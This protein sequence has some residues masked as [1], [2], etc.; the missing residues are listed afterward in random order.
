MAAGPHP[1]RLSRLAYARRVLRDDFP[2][3]QRLRGLATPAACRGSLTLAAYF[4]TTFR[5]VNDSVGLPSRRLS[6][7]AYARRV[8]RDDFPLRQ[9]LRRLAIR[10]LSRL[11]YPRRA[12]RDAF[13]PSD[14]RP[15]I[16]RA[17]REEVCPCSRRFAPQ[18]RPSC[19]STSPAGWP[20]S[21]CP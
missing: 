1:R 11:A 17:Y 4:A 14:D 6:R 2:L 7:L 9:R 13:P 18:A 21:A 20:S 16:S 5:L 3:G 15:A 8:L 12:L 19:P 10:R